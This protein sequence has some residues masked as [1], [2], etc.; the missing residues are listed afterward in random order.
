MIKFGCPVVPDELIMKWHND[1]TYG[2]RFRAFLDEV[3][4]ESSRASLSGLSRAVVLVI[5]Y[6]G[7]L[8]IV[9]AT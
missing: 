4:D 2:P 6:L 7:N 5:R 1:P 3:Y 8:V 9:I